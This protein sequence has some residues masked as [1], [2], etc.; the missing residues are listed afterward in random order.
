[1][2]GPRRLTVHGGCG[3]GSVGFV[4]RSSK[5][6]KVCKSV[7]DKHKKYVFKEKQQVGKTNHTIH[8]DLKTC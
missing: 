3:V 2:L 5:W 1:M 8:F 6:S 7:F 4:C